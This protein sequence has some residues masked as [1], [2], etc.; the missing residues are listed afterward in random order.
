MKD[1]DKKRWFSLPFSKS[2]KAKVAPVADPDHVVPQVETAVKDSEPKSSV[3]IIV[4]GNST[5]GKSTLM[6][7][8][9]LLSNRYL[10]DYCSHY[11][12]LELA[13]ER[14]VDVINGMNRKSFDLANTDY[15]QH[16]RASGHNDVSAALREFACGV[17][18]R[19][20]LRFNIAFDTDAAQ[21]WRD[22]ITALWK[23]PQIREAYQWSCKH[24]A[25][26][27]SV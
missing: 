19:G 2:S 5:S 23:D 18:Q 14:M 26:P 20:H 10:D 22:A 1:K 17:L 8:A 4:Y 15:M 25:A 7:S 3:N 27:D 6:K 9:N 24:Y 13:V 12:M 21:T 16:L 11:G